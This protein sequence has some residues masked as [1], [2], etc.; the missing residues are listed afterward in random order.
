MDAAY[1]SIFTAALIVYCGCLSRSDTSSTVDLV[2][3]L[4]LAS[5]AALVK[6]VCEL[7]FDTASH[8]VDLNC[9]HAD[10]KDTYP[11]SVLPLNLAAPFTGPAGM[12]PPLLGFSTCTVLAGYV[13]FC[14]NQPFLMQGGKRHSR[15]QTP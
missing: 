12:L 11:G 2:N 8:L 10:A 4:Q 14:H 7:C 1:S 3:S 5:L 6:C 13:T 9:Q 15:S